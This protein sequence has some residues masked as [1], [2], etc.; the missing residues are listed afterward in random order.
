MNDYQ[1]CPTWHKLLSV[2]T[3]QGVTTTERKLVMHAQNIKDVKSQLRSL[4]ANE[5]R[6]LW[7]MHRP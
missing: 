1:K 4:N 2:R 7:N 3:V 6:V 5:V